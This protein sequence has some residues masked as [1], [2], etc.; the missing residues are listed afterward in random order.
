MS[1]LIYFSAYLPWVTVG[2]GVTIE[3]LKEDE[4]FGGRCVLSVKGY[5]VLG[6]VFT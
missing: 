6:S 5:G 2:V 3:P 1:I 4:K